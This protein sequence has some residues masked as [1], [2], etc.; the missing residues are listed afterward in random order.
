MYTNPCFIRKNTPELIKKLKE[1][2][3]EPMNSDDTTLDNHNYDGKGTHR[4]IEDGTAIITYNSNHYGIVYDIDDVV[5]HNRIDC[6]ENEDLFLAIAALRNDSDMYQWYTDIPG[7]WYKC[8]FNEGWKFLFFHPI[9]S[10][11]NG[12]KATVKELINHFK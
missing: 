11:Y 4:K 12:H 7:H 5:K 3:L 6:G 8:T 9:L 10:D 1:I 2:G